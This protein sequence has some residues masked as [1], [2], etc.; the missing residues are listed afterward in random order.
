MIIK[1]DPQFDLLIKDLT[2]TT[3]LK[4]CIGVGCIVGVGGYLGYLRAKKK[5]LSKK[6]AF[7]ILG[8][9]TAST[10]FFCG[11]QKAESVKRVSL[12]IQDLD[13]PDDWTPPEKY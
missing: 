7:I 13:V 12:L 11:A 4:G 9:A 2:N 6:D 5:K 1:A 10:Y 3:I 8:G